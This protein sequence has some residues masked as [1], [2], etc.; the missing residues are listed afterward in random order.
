M[1]VEIVLTSVDREGTGEG[2]DIELLEKVSVEI[3]VPL[4]VR[5]GH[6]R[7]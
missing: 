1:G 5:G 3:F 7:Y 2:F 6:L 4:V